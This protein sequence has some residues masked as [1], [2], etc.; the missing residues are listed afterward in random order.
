MSKIQD[1]LQ[2]LNSVL[3]SGNATS[4]G[5]VGFRARNSTVRRYIQVS[6]LFN[7]RQMVHENIGYRIYVDI[8]SIYIYIFFFLQNRVGFG[9]FYCKREVL[10]DGIEQNEAPESGIDTLEDSNV[11]YFDVLSPLGLISWCN[12]YTD[13]IWFRSACHLFNF[14]KAEHNGDLD[15]KGKIRNAKTPVDAAKLGM[16]IKASR[17]TDIAS[18]PNYV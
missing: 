16:T 14:L 18:S 12:I 13:I 15:M 11:H 7:T 8:Q 10:A 1:P 17:V 4:V 5:N 9:Y 6:S 3:E 2:T